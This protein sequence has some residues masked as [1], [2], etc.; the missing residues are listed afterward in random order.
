M[1][2]HEIDARPI[3]E[4]I[5]IP[6][7]QL[8]FF[9]VVSQLS[10]VKRQGWL[11]R[12]IESPESVAE[13]S[14]Q[15]AIMSTFEA[16]RRGLDVQKTTTMALIHDL[17]EIYAGD[18][19]PYQHL[20]DEQRAEAILHWTPPSEEALKDKHKKEEEALQKITQ[21]LPMEFRTSIMALWEEY[22]EG[23]TEEARL[24]R[25]MDR[26]QRLLQAEKYRSQKESFPIDSFLQEALTSD[27]PEIKRL[28]KKI[29]KD[30]NDTTSSLT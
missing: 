4:N 1:N 13:H 20:P 25:R 9:E 16:K 19:T 30:I 24:V 14:Y 7:S 10:E 17:S 5:R 8:N 22:N 12:G 3:R 2:N 27:D 26:M 11:D 6:K 28:A 23:Q 29:Q 21:R 15:V 18:I